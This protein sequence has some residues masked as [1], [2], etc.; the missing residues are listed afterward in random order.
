MIL[1]SLLSILFPP[2]CLHCEV[3]LQNE[4]VLCNACFSSIYTSRTPFC[5]R[6][7]SRLPRNKKE[8]H[9]N[10]PYLLLA[11]GNYSSEP[12]KKLILGLK[13]K[14]L[15]RAAKP[16]TKLMI[17]YVEGLEINLKNFV[18]VPV[19]L[20]KNRERM[21]GF[22]QAALL[23]EPLAEHFNLPILKNNL[24]R[25]LHTK[26]QSEERTLQSRKKNVAGC[27]AVHEPEV[28]KAKNVLLIDDVSTSGATL[29][30]ASQVLKQ[31][32]AKKIFALVSARA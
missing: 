31:A 10:F 30:E 6:C 1:E 5:G 32:G 16:L 28:F 21:R 2:R 18:V 13:F 22:N 19:P 3:G 23:A 11:A 8:C 24:V 20:S 29:T 27:F 9:L 4:E 25:I 15:T 7:G 14:Y 26:P 12:L 17:S